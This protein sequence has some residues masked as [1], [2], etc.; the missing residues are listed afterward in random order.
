MKQPLMAKL[1]L[2]LLYQTRKIISSSVHLMK[3][4]KIIPFV[5]IENKSY[6]LELGPV[7][8]RIYSISK[9]LEPTFSCKGDK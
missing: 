2:E 1:S 3:K 7:S 6:F 9:F 4:L 5:F 8:L